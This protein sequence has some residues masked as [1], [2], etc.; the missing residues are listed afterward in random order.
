MILMVSI[1]SV[2]F[3]HKKQHDLTISVTFWYKVSPNE[4][5][6]VH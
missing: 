5:I 1:T 4:S 3:D 2:D 6:K